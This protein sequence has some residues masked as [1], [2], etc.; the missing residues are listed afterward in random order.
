MHTTQQLFVTDRPVAEA[1]V[2]RLAANEVADVDFHLFQ[3]VGGSN[4][5]AAS[6]SIAATSFGQ[7]Y[8]SICVGKPSGCKPR[9]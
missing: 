5:V 1:T 3:S 2:W 9:E 6:I 8:S 7:M 4:P